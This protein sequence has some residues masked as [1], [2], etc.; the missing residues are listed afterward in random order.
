MASDL[1]LHLFRKGWGSLN[2]E[3]PGH[4]FDIVLASDSRVFIEHSLL[5]WTILHD[6][7]CFVSPCFRLRDAYLCSSICPTWEKWSGPMVHRENV[8]ILSTC[9]KTPSRFRIAPPKLIVRFQFQSPSSIIL[10]PIYELI[11][12]A[13]YVNLGIPGWLRS[14][15]WFF[16]EF[17]GLSKLPST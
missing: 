17:S 13:C 16:S 6:Y 14:Y 10:D 2:L 3:T 12:V 9:V 4:G 7:W 5:S 8:F 11:L 1:P 15:Q